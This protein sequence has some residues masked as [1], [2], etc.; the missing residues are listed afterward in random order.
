MLIVSLSTR[1]FNKKQTKS[2][3]LHLESVIQAQHANEIIQ[4]GLP[5]SYCQMMK[6][7]RFSYTLAQG[8]G[9]F[10]SCYICGGGKIQPVLET[11]QLAALQL[12]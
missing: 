7:K 8:V 11:T 6:S 3:V 1:I 4:D 12:F 5:K 9:G 2:H 10:A